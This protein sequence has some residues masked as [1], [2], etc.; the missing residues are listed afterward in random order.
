MCLAGLIL[1]PFYFP[2]N[3][4]CK[5]C[6]IGWIVPWEIIDYHHLGN[7]PEQE[8]LLGPSIQ[9]VPVVPIFGNLFHSGNEFPCP[10]ILDH[11]RGI[12]SVSL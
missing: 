7:N 3:F 6:P 9:Y 12:D 5:F 4:P 10:S 1:R 2:N 11:Q 8:K